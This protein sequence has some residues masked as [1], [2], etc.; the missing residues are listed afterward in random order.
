MIEIDALCLTLETGVSVADVSALAPEIVTLDHQIVA[1]LDC[2]HI[3]GYNVC[4]RYLRAPARCRFHPRR[5]NRLVQPH[6]CGLQI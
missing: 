4:T 1:S 6:V 5:P 2:S 3:L